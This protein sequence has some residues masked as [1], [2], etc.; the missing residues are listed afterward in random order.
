MSSIQVPLSI[1]DLAT[2]IAGDTSPAEA[3]K[4]SVSFAQRAEQLA[5][6]RYWFAEHHNMESVASSATSVLIGHVAGATKSIRVGS[7]GV[8]LPNHA[9][10]VIAE[11]FGTLEALYPGRIDLGLGRA[12]GTDQSTAHA[13]RRNLNADVDN[14][15]SD[16]A[17]LL[18]YLGPRD[19]TM[20][21]KAIPGVDSMIPVWLLGSSTYS[22]QLA[23]MMGLP[24][25]I[26]SHFAPT[27]LHEAFRLYRA[28]FKPSP[29]LEK[30]YAMACVSVIAADTDEEADVLAT[31]FYQMAL[32]M[33][34]NVRRPLQPPLPSMKGVWTPAEEAG[35]RNMMQYAIIGSA[36]TVHASLQKFID[37][38]GVDEIMVT[39][40][41]FDFGKK[42]K[43]LE[44]VGQLMR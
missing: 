11:Q 2:I 4:R 44:L 12:P 31:S 42:V 16:V 23:A 14:F 33:F 28:N 38:T 35:V 25:A 36:E 13:L 15:P 18:Q 27:Y 39:T 34:R 21:V 37:N 30:P 43:S 8:M 20:K 9:P 5:F 17:E 6:R 10:L 3:F 40:N 7:G 29:F 1:L 19:P 24:F 32:G 26:A 41:V 22:A